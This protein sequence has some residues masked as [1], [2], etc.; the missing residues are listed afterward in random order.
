MARILI[1]ARP[2]FCA[3]MFRGGPR[4]SRVHVA[5][6][7]WCRGD[8]G[9]LLFLNCR[10][11]KTRASKHALAPI[12]SKKHSSVWRQTMRVPRKV[13]F[14]LQ[15]LPW[16]R[17]WIYAPHDLQG[18]FDGVIAPMAQEGKIT[19]KDH[20]GEMMKFAVIVGKARHAHEHWVRHKM[21][22]EIKNIQYLHNYD[23]RNFEKTLPFP[24]Y[25]KRGH[26]DH[27][28]TGAPVK[29]TEEGG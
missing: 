7:A 27:F 28:E 11:E 22:T 1:V 14:P 2:C 23:P 26:L 19:K 18:Y 4:A 9:D 3:F 24:V 5:L 15:K 6:L 21:K 20:W 12:P 29:I 8:E 10:G 13:A 25:N 17:T 16:H